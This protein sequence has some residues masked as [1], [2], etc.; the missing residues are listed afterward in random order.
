MQ[1]KKD[2]QKP[3][4]IC[5]EVSLENRSY[6]GKTI[7]GKKYQKALLGAIQ[8]MGI[9]DFFYGESEKKS[10][11]KWIRKKRLF[12]SI[13]EKKMTAQNNKG[14]E[15]DL[16]DYVK[17]DSPSFS[18]PNPKAQSKGLAFRIAAC[19]SLTIIGNKEEYSLNRKYNYIWR[20]LAPLQFATV[21]VF[22]L[23]CP[24]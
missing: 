16:W 10:E 8:L 5:F 15:K 1:Y 17:E 20:L 21:R 12:S 2:T 14:A 7:L 6:N 3:Y 19:L 4:Q 13:K 18:F 9:R 11:Q 24:F 22:L 23:G